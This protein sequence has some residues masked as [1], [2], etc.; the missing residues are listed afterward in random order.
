MLLVDFDLMKTLEKVEGGKP[1]GL[2]ECSEI[3]LE[4]GEWVRVLVRVLIEVTEIQDDAEGSIRLAD[5]LR[6]RTE[7]AAGTFDNPLFE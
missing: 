2:A 5:K 3:T 1:V 7:A 6:C 4:I